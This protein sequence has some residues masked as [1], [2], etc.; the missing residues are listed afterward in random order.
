M[1][2]LSEENVGAG[3]KE[4][5]PHEKL[6]LNQ[7]F[8]R[9]VR[10]T[11][12]PECG[13]PDLVEDYDVGEISCHACGL[14]IRQPM[15]S[16]RIGQHANSTLL[17]NSGNDELKSWLETKFQTIDNR[18]SEVEKSLSSNKQTKI[19]KAWYRTLLGMTELGGKT[20]TEQL[21]DHLTISRSVVS[22]YL[23]RME[24]EGIVERDFSEHTKD[25]SRFVWQINWTSLPPE[26]GSR[27]RKMPMEDPVK[28]IS[29]I[30]TRVEI[31]MPTQ[32]RAIRIINEAKT[33]GIVA[34]NDPMG[35]AAAALCVACVIDGE[36]KTQKEISE[37]ANVT[38]VTV[39]NRY[40]QLKDALK[41][42]I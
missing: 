22:E 25:G 5:Q 32:Q 40:E 6:E 23:N 4:A 37:V 8:D 18:L 1:S 15:T 34:G 16:T 38:E 21:A 19:R 11:N 39:R 31:S 13:S 29:K 24:E 35:L 2:F 42:D 26:I 14:V 20:G 12:C 9:A 30:A 33:K 3:T 7:A 17:L 10:L 36:K 28:C 27:L 41:L